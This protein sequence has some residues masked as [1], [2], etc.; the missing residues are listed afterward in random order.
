M[1]ERTSSVNFILPRQCFFSRNREDEEL[2]QE[3][4]EYNDDT[5]YDNSKNTKN[6]TN[7]RREEHAIDGEESVKTIKNFS[8]SQKKKKSRDK[9]SR[10][11]THKNVNLVIKK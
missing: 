4:V 6:T 2:R 7:E 3:N 11:K 9:T 8:V 10:R 1:S 5:Y